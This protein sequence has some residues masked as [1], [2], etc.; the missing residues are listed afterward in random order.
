MSEIQPIQHNIINNFTVGDYVEFHRIYLLP[1]HIAELGEAVSSIIFTV[2]A[3]PNAVDTTALIKKTITTTESLTHGLIENDVGGEIYFTFNLQTSDT[4][5]FV[6]DSQ[7]YYDI[8]LV[9]SSGKTFVAYN[10]LIIANLRVGN[11]LNPTAITPLTELEEISIIVPTELYNETQVKK[12]LLKYQHLR[13]RDLR[14]LLVAETL[15]KTGIKTVKYTKREIGKQ[16]YEGA[17]DNYRS[18]LSDLAGQIAVLEA[19]IV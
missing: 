12:L 19:V 4:E 6:N 17:G 14:I 1:S 5:L 3:D 8:R 7:Y 11:S 13:N 9:L 10:G 15:I 2:K 16:K 18:I